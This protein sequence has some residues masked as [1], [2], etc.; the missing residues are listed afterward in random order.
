MG[1]HGE[2]QC[3]ARGKSICHATNLLHSFLEP[4]P[5]NMGT[6]NPFWEQVWKTPHCSHK[7]RHL[8]VPPGFAKC[9]QLLAWGVQR[10]DPS[11]S[12]PLHKGTGMYSLHWSL[13]K[14]CRWTL[15]STKLLPEDEQDSSAPLRVI[16]GPSTT[17]VAPNFTLAR[18]PCVRNASD[19][20]PPLAPVAEGKELSRLAEQRV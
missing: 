13:P 20:A 5:K 14:L 19:I 8:G 11:F 17:L 4:Q 9:Q 3:R 2:P 10:C 6:K 7:T 16:T 1:E 18:G 15:R 12:F